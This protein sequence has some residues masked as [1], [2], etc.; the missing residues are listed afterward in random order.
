MG[1]SRDSAFSDGFAPLPALLLT[2]LRFKWP[3]LLCVFSFGCV[4]N[5][6]PFWRVSHRPVVETVLRNDLRMVLGRIEAAE[7]FMKFNTFIQ[8]VCTRRMALVRARRRGHRLTRPVHLFLR[9][10]SGGYRL[11]VQ[12]YSECLV[13]MFMLHNEVGLAGWAARPVAAPSRSCL[14]PTARLN[15]QTVNIWSH[16]FGLA[17]IAYAFVDAMN[18]F[19][20]FAS[21]VDLLI[22][23]GFFIGASTMFFMSAMYHTFMCHSFSVRF[24]LAFSPASLT[25]YSRSLRCPIAVVA[26]TTGVQ[27]RD[28]LGLC[29]HLL[30]DLWLD[31]VGDARALLLLRRLAAV[32]SAGLWHDVCAYVS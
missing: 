21:T 29:G 7:E 30:H 32:L 11:Q 8:Y 14:T 9:A 16:I 22:F 1:S 19:Y 6:P 10:R 4:A 12:H 2:R 17:A 25:V 13:S 20:P 31:A 27:L 15:L 23:V 18:R 3:A 26:V 24:V 28:D 5:W